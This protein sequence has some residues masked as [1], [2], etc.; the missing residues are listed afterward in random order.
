LTFDAYRHEFGMARYSSVSSA[1]DRI[2]KKRQNDSNFLK[3]ERI[4]GFAQERSS[5]RSASFARQ[6]SLRSESF[7]LRSASFAG[8]DARQANGDLTITLTAVLAM[9]CA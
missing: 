8:Q 3:I 6:A 2:K 9:G 7:Q 4:E 5:L 1:V